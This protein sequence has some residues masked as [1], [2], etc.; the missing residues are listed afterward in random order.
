MPMP[1][2]AD[3]V[4]GRTLP[5][6]ALQ[7]WT[8]ALLPAFE[9]PPDIAADVAE[10]LVASDRHHASR[11]AMD[12][13]IEGTRASGSYTAVVRNS[14]HY[15]I[16]GWYA[17]RAAADLGQAFIAIDPDALDEPGAFEARVEAEF[18]LLTASPTVPDAPGRI[19]IHGEPEADAE[20]RTA[21]RGVVMDL[22]HHATLE[23]LGQRARVPFPETSPIE[24]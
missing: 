2:Y 16:A 17:L 15:G 7:T 13:A 12:A 23:E 10:V 3:P 11:V 1:T 19:L 4:G 21:A 22:E 9:T 14:N 5:A 24:G 18:E 6:A 8:A 20:R